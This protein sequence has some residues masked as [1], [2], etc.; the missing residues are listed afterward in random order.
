MSTTKH[1]PGP[2]E[3]DDY[4][5][6]SPANERLQIREQS[7]RIMSAERQ[8]NA[9]LIAAAPEL[10][11]ACHA[12]CRAFCITRESDEAEQAALNDAYNK[13]RAAIARAEVR[14]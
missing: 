2:W 4:A 12:I 5:V 1:T 10:L 3:A 8:A 9:R 6:Q 11:E 14:P 7:V 13:C